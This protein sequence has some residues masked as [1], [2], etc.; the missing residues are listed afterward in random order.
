M[1][2][3]AN[4]GEEAADSHN[5]RKGLRSTSRA[6]S[7]MTKRAPR[8]ALVSV[9]PSRLATSSPPSRASGRTT[10][11]RQLEASTRSRK[12]SSRQAPKYTSISS[13]LLCHGGGLRKP[14]RPSAGPP[15]PC[16]DN[17][18]DARAMGQNTRY[19]APGFH[20]RNLRTTQRLTRSLTPT[21]KCYCLLHKSHLFGA[22]AAAQLQYAPLHVC[23][24]AICMLHVP[25]LALILAWR[26]SA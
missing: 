15:P 18:I 25:R 20:G 7:R 13:I 12:S 2:T 26:A 6:R 10:Q 11:P 16:Q 19:V 5:F 4:L 24:T 8:L 1:R 3:R 23:D 9:A 22:A 14:F 21:T 17:L